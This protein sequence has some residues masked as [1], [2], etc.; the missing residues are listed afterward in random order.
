MIKEKTNKDYIL[1]V[2]STGKSDEWYLRMSPIETP[3]FSHGI[4]LGANTFKTK[5]EAEEHKDEVWEYISSAFNLI[6]DDTQLLSSDGVFFWCSNCG[7]DEESQKEENWVRL[8]WNFCP[9]CGQKF[10]RHKKH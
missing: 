9:N 10:M 6:E 5:K 4:S 2:Y 3:K 8:A 7:S 1:N